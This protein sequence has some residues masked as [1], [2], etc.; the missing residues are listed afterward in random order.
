[1]LRILVILLII[2]TFIL[3][4]I[5]AFQWYSTSGEYEPKITLLLAIS[6]LLIFLLGAKGHIFSFY[7]S[8]T[9]DR[10]SF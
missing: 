4:I 8:S 7:F 10:L 1:M 3:A 9:L 2:V 6:G 5:S